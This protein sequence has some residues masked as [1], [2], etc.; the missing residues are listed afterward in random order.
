V[1]DSSSSRQLSQ[2]ELSHFLVSNE[3]KQTKETDYMHLLL[4]CVVAA[5]VIHSNCGT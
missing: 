3:F 5:V 1:A 2:V 4:S